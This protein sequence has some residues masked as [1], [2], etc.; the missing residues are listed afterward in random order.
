MGNV[1]FAF[2]TNHSANGETYRNFFRVLTNFAIHHVLL[3][4]RLFTS[5]TFRS[6]SFLFGFAGTSSVVYFWF[7]I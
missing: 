2:I 5:H 1:F 3:L 7:G 6:L 4:E